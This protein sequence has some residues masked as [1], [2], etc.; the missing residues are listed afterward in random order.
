MHHRKLKMAT[1][2]SGTKRQPSLGP[3][4]SFLTIA[5]YDPRRTPDECVITADVLHA[6]NTVRVDVPILD[7]NSQQSVCTAVQNLEHVCYS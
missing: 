6:K 3:S 4:F 7:K 1:V 5:S 2:F